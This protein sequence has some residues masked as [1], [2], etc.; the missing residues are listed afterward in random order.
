[1]KKIIFAD[2]CE[3]AEYMVH[4][5]DD[6][7]CI[8]SVLFFDSAQELVKRLLAYDCVSVGV[9]DLAHACY[10]GYEKEYYVNLSDDYV[11][12]V[13]KAYSGD[14]YLREDADILLIHGD[15]SAKIISNNS[16]KFY[17]IS[18]ESEEQLDSYLS[19][20]D[21]KSEDTEIKVNFE[22]NYDRLVNLLIDRLF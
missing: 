13:E 2:I 21:D 6:V 8:A 5:V 22:V 7:D 11:L 4:K 10:N 20:Y 14:E 12:S 16:S 3:L 1:M 19:Q 18:F 15:A 17:E 9:I